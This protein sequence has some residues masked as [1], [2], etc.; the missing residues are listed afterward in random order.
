MKMA[1][2]KVVSSGTSTPAR[3]LRSSIPRCSAQ[4][5]AAMTGSTA[6]SATKGEMSVASDDQKD[7]A[8]AQ[9]REIAVGQ[10]DDPHHPEHERKAAGEQRV[11]AAEQDAVEE[12]AWPRSWMLPAAPCRSPK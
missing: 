7:Q 8:G 11:I 2:P 12:S 1:R 3:R 4:P 5:M 10:I 9:D 6:M